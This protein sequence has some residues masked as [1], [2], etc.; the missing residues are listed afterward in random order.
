[1][2]D[3]APHGL[4]LVQALTGEEVEEVAAFAQRRVQAYQVD[5]GAMLVGR[6][7]TGLLVQM[8]VAYNCP[9]GLPAAASEVIGTTGQITAERTMG[10]T[11]GGVV[12]RICGRLGLDSTLHVPDAMPRPSRARWTPSPAG[13]GRAAM[14]SAWSETCA[15]CGLIERAYASCR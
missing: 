10:Q 15:A 14:P 7:G 1:M 6:T 3:L 12:R 2:M 4:D 9:E 13:C 11:P 5:D 8:H